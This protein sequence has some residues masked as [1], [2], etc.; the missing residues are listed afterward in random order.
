MAPAP[1][2]PCLT[3]GRHRE[4]AKNV[5]DFLAPHGFSVNGI[6]S[7]NKWSPS[8]LAVALRVLEPSPQALLIGGG[9]SDEEAANARAAFDA[10]M[11][12][13]DIP[14]GKVVRVDPG[15]ID[16]VGPKGVAAWVLEQLQAHF[17]D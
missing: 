2:V 8:D 10:Y 4:I 15:V 14:N 13:L 5:A 9:Y 16:K 7:M 1:Q 11:K 6:L 12:E 3:L 17:R